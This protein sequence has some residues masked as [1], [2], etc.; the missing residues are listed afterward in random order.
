[1]STGAGEVA[2]MVE[3]LPSIHRT[4]GS[5]PSIN[6]VEMYACSFNRQRQE[7]QEFRASLGYIGS[8]RPA[9]VT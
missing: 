3:C 2:Q 7:D 6:G 8:L 5:A 4:L 1:M 9:S